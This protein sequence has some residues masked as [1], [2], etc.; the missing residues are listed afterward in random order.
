MKKSLGSD[1]SIIAKMARKPVIANLIVL[2]LIIGGYLAFTVTTQEVFP[3]FSDDSVIITV[4]HPGTSAAEIERSILLPIENALSG[5][6][7]IDELNAEAREGQGK[8]IA[9]LSNSKDD[10]VVYQDIKNMVDSLTTL[11]ANANKPLVSLSRHKAEVV[12]MILY[13]D[14]SRIELKKYANLVHD[15]LSDN[16][17]LGAIEI[18]GLSDSAIYIEVPQHVLSKHELGI[19]DIAKKVQSW[20]SNT[21]GGIVRSKNGDILLQVNENRDVANEYGNI[22]IF[23]SN[24]GSSLQLKNIATINEKLV[25]DNNYANFNGKNAVLI[26]IFRSEGQTPVGVS[27]EVNKQLKNIK[28]ILP[29]QIGVKLLD[30]R[31]KVFSARAELLKNNGLIGFVLVVIMLGLF[32][33]LR[34]AAWVGASIP[35]VFC[36]T[37]LFFPGL[38]LSVNLITM[39]AFIISLGIVV[40]D[41]IIIGENVF[42]Y[43]EQGYAP[44]D[45]AILG[46]KEV[47]SPVIYSVL[48]NIVAFVPLFFVPG[49]MGK[50]FVYIPAVVVIVFA[51]SLLESLFVLPAHLASIKSVD[52]KYKF[53]VTITALQHKFNVLILEQAQKKYKKA[54]QLALDYR[55][56]VLATVFSIF[57]IILSLAISGRMGIVLFPDIESNVATATVSL[58]PGV[59]QA[60]IA[61]SKDELYKSAKMA[62]AEVSEGDIA[63]GILVTVLNNKVKAK[64]YLVDGALRATGT[65]EVIE[66]WKRNW[67]NNPFVEAINFSVNEKGPASDSDL[68]IELKHTDITTLKLAAVWLGQQLAGYKV[69]ADIDDGV[70]KGRKQWSFTLNKNAIGL[71]FNTEDISAQIRSAFYGYKVLE[72][73]RGREDIDVYVRLPEVERDSKYE[74]NNFILRTPNNVEVLL[75]DVVTTDKETANHNITRRNGFRVITLTAAAEPKSETINVQK[76]LEKNALIELKKRFPGIS[77]SFEGKQADMLASIHYLLLGFVFAIG[78]MYSLLVILFGSF[79]KPILIFFMVPF[80]FIGVAIG[81]YIMG[82]PLSIL[83]L[84]GMVALTGIVINDGLV[85]LKFIENNMQKSKNVASAVSGAA[86]RRLFPA[87]LTSITTFVGLLPMI[88]ERSMQAKFLIPMAIALGF[89]ALGALALTLFV[90]PILYTVLADIKNIFGQELL[91]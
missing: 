16:E 41:A 58:A 76:S 40:D 12:K 51:I 31:S 35:I 69:L 62:I 82:Y 47:A 8:V 80:S 44:L 54:L 18:K 74:I 22:P 67:V 24:V 4:S 28:N 64:I 50:I 39:F 68:T 7:G 78:A 17:N 30:D 60:V 87:F 56:I 73:S 20:A 72:Q 25:D 45:A 75:K 91:V 23:Q 65:S 2:L 88:L 19:R 33:G 49:V 36:G 52:P 85:L 21:P 89:G 14:I 27:K 11:P 70:S 29:K 13:G 79:T 48:T 86:V 43:R 3:D 10:F 34:F 1:N 53:M 26:N 6:K 81:N 38:D 77:Y 15:Y 90:L 5:I 84:F 83:S 59:S 37:F 46:T 9:K 32:M 66:L 71:G 55:Y 63:E 42:S 61:N 57:I